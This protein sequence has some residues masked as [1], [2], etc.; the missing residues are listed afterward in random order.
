MYC[1]TD[2]VVAETEQIPTVTSS[3]SRTGIASIATPKAKW[4]PFNWSI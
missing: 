2:I 4:E 3:I 1:A